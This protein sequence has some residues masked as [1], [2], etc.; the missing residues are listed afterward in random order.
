VQDAGVH[1]LVT[2]D[3]WTLNE[4]NITSVEEL[5]QDLGTVFADD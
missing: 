5:L 4:K 2:E 1:I 3:G